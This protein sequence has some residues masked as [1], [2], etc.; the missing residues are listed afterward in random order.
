MRCKRPCF[1]W[2]HC[3]GS[4]SRPL[5]ANQNSARNDAA[6]T[7]LAALALSA[8]TQ[9]RKYGY[10]LRS[11][12]ELLPLNDDA[13]FE[14][15]VTATTGKAFSLSD[16]EAADLL[17]QAVGALKPTGFAWS[18]KPVRLTPKKALVDLVKQSRKLAEMDDDT[19]E[20]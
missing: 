1:P 14:I 7:V 13:A 19:A 9:Q 4:D 15:V 5:T 10:S 17:R 16:A 2:R 6:R 8:V 3:V 20:A 18:E 12:C 11:R